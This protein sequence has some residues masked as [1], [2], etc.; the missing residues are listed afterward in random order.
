[1][2]PFHFPS[3]RLNSTT[4]VLLQGWLWHYITHEGWYAIKQRHQTTHMLSLGKG[5][6][7]F[8]PASCKSNDTTD[9]L[10]VWL[11]H[12]ITHEGWYAI[13]ETNTFH[14]TKQVETKF[15]STKQGHNCEC[16]AAGIFG[17]R[18]I[19]SYTRYNVKGYLTNW[20]PLLKLKMISLDQWS[21][22]CYE[23][24]VFCGLLIYL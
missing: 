10:E 6:N 20:T 19:E 2:N 21:Q 15:G 3:Y 7:S 12:Y 5:M 4:T 8:I 9:V 11:W 24:Q 17:K 14:V 22:T 16:A 23:S 13:K 18:I 1:M